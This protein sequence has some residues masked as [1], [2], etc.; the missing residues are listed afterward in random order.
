MRFLSYIIIATVCMA[1]AMQAQTFTSYT[2][3]DGLINNNING[4]AVDNA[5]KIWL[6]TQDGLSSF[7]PVSLA[8]EAIN[9]TS[10][11]DLLDNV[12]NCIEIAS[13]G[14]IWLGTDLGIS[15]YDGTNW[16]SFTD[17]DGLGANRIRTIKE[18]PT[19]KVWVGENNGL[20]VYDGTNWTAYGTADGLPFGG[21]TSFDFVGVD[22]D[23]VIIGTGLGGVMV[24][25]GTVFNPITEADGLLSDRITAVAVGANNHKW[26][27][28]ASG[29]SVLDQNNQ[30]I[31]SH[32]R[33]YILP[34]PDTLNPV[35]SIALDNNG[36]AWVG[37]YVDYLVTV[38]G[39]AVNS[40][41]G[42]EDYDQTDGLVG[43]AVRAI[44]VDANND[45]WV[46]TSSGLS[47]ISGTTTHLEEELNA[48]FSMYPNPALGQLNIQLDEPLSANTEVAILDMSMR[49]VVKSSLSA[50]QQ[51]MRMNLGTLTR[52][53]YFVRIGNHVERLMI[54]R[55]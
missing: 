39:I 28:T 40:G 4:I 22:V 27:G 31:A 18:G 50:G 17:T 34:P 24:F 29:V 8:W 7:D 26:I 20:S 12:I 43:P 45:V 53:L 1:S 16:Q 2:E 44:A 23:E 48:A 46:G 33:M 41:F 13:N 42:W 32:S 38:G 52:G 25:D 51:S 15:V 3:A 5:G 19:G 9:Q 37:I 10:S 14:D 54:G 11:P 21:V 36:A 49:T 35:T 30:V 6:A 47:H 55:Q